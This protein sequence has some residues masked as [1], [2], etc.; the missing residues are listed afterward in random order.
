MQMQRHLRQKNIMESG[1]N[2][3]KTRYRLRGKLNNQYF[4]LTVSYFPDIIL[5]AM[6]IYSKHFTDFI[7]EQLDETGIK[8][9]SISCLQSLI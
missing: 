3:Q 2:M 9:T 4:N 5:H 1:L 8:T 6:I 7:I